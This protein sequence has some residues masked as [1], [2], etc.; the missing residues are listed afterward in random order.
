MCF[1]FC[2]F[3]KDM[4]FFIVSLEHDYT[5]MEFPVIQRPNF[6]FLF[7]PRVSRKI[8]CLY[9]CLSSRRSELSERGRSVLRLFS[10]LICWYFLSLCF[11]FVSSSCSDTRSS[12]LFNFHF[13][14]SDRR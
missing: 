9:I 12:S 11:F 3:I 1:S 8:E 5:F 13:N 4:Y 6:L 14:I 10:H 7:R 2:A